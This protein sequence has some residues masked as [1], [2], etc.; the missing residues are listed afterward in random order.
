MP[1]VSPFLRDVGI[2]AWSSGKLRKN[3][4]T[5]L[6]FKGRG[7]QPRRKSGKITGAFRRWGDLQFTK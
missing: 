5:G 1:H 6:Y 2:Q 7:F 4:H 3:A